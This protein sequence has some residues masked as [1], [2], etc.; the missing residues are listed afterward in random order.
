M[1]HFS[2]IWGHRTLCHSHLVCDAFLQDAL[3]LAW[4]MFL[5]AECGGTFTILN[6]G[7]IRSLLESVY[8]PF[9]R[10]RQTVSHGQE[11][12]TC[13]LPPFVH[14]E[15]VCNR[16]ADRSSHWS[17]SIPY[18][19]GTGL[20]PGHAPF[21]SGHQRHSWKAR[22][23]PCP[24]PHPPGPWASSLPR[25]LVSGSGLSLAGHGD[26]PWLLSTYYSVGFINIQ[27][28]L[29]ADVM[30]SMCTLSKFMSMH[31]CMKW[32]P[33]CDGI[34]RRDLWEVIRWWGWSHHDGISALIRSVR[35]ARVWLLSLLSAMWAQG[36]KTAFY[37]QQ[38][39]LIRHRLGR[40]PDRSQCGF[41][42]GLQPFKWS[43]AMAGVLLVSFT[44]DIPAPWTGTLW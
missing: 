43:Y 11:R 7:S 33:Q 1:R 9:K 42:A 15:L 19:T 23:N 8:S 17:Q 44:D 27:C 32:N 31:G 29:K 34:W 14:G 16:M 26:G 30:H 36:E 39:A 24:Q 25:L 6:S 21:I 38:G 2:D 22:Q 37:N 4:F 28:F 13:E 12:P 20:V 18:R 5:P 41:C 35:R 10:A 40:H 3:D